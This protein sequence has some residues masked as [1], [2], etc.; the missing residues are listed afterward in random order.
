MLLKSVFSIGA[1]SLLS[2]F[3]GPLCSNSLAQATTDFDLTQ[4]HPKVASAVAAIRETIK[5]GPFDAEWK[6]LER[7]QIPQ[8]YKDAKFGIFIHWGAYSVPAFGSEW[9]P[10]QM[11]IDKNRRGDNFFQHHLNTYGPQKEFGYKDFIPQFKAEKFDAQQWARLF[12]D[13]GAK[14][15]IPV[16][17]HHDGFPM[18][19]CSYTK[20]NSTEMGPKRDVIQ[21]LS[22][23]VRGAGMKFGLSSHR[24]FNWVFYVRSED[25][26][27]ADP[28]YA[29]LYGRPMPFLFAAD[30]SNY[31]KNFPPQDDQFKDDWLARSC[32]LVDRYK[33]DVFWFDFGIAP[34]R[35]LSYQENHFADHLKQ[36]AAY[37]YNQSSEWDG[38]VGII[39]YKWNAFPELAAVYDKERSKEAAIRKP[40]WQT[41]TAVSSS[42]WG[43]T[44]DQ[45]YKTPDRL[46]DDLVD[47]VSKNG[48][49]L[50]NVGPRAD[51]TIPEQDQAILKAIGGWLK[52]NGESIYDTTHWKIFGEGPT[53]VSSGHVAEKNDKRFTAKD[54]RFT[55]KDGTLFVTGLAWPEDGK[56]VVTLLAEGSD[57][58][59]EEIASVEMLGSDAELQWTRDQTG[60]KVELPKEHPS[61]FAYVLTVKSGSKKKLNAKRDTEDGKK[62]EGGGTDVGQNTDLNPKTFPFLLPANKPNKP[63]SAAMQRNYDG[64]MA[65]RPEDNPL[66][67]QFKYTRLKGF[68]YNGGDGTIS[69]RDPSKV[70]FAN[71]KYYVWYTKRETLTPPQG[72]DKSTDTIPSSDWD[73]CD[74][75][76]A[77]STDGFT[78]EEQGIAI[79]R[80]EK[81]QVG[82]RSVSTTDIL[83]WKGKYYLYYQGF[84][85]A[86][87]KRGDDCPVAVSYA[88]SPDGPWVA[89]HK[90]VIPN[91]PKGSWDQYSI[92]DPYPIVRD[93]KI[94]I[95]YKSDFDGD[96]RLIRMQGLVTGDD[97]LG[98]F[99]KHPLNPV[100]A[101]GHE[102]TLFPF[103]EGMAALVTRDGN[104]HNTVQYAADGV[105]FE[106][107]AHVELLPAAA[108]PFVADAFTDTQDGRGITWGIS[109]FTAV[110]GWKTNHAILARFDCDLS[111]DLDDPEMKRHHIYLSPEIHFQ[112]KL[113]GKQR[114]RITTSN[115]TRNATRNVI[116]NGKFDKPDN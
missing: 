40:F 51:G 106:V 87:G 44:E 31:Q 107:A 111:Q 25:F 53:G 57:L 12:K 98:P 66:Y 94:Y 54:L 30:A 18:Y 27:N 83:V 85:E 114:K 49:L 17:E 60:L 62:G 89:H 56:V 24:A 71:G 91:G 20:W 26:D 52:I 13:T 88:D 97:P 116:G 42:S 79:P 6:S 8:W 68:D 82:W 65:P 5:A 32:E 67:S 64:F 19:D 4:P 28:Q 100:I 39:N 3:S 102:T 37:Y 61:E 84:M 103:K 55:A 35:K 99:R 77:T 81:P 74:I 11:Y 29:D 108:G 112:Q 43:Y 59:P 115:Q 46:V 70:I 1:I 73:L 78:W 76:Y 2:L 33:P 63:L 95:Y 23:A 7:Y 45:K 90:V 109:H 15:V 101:S 110:N 58:Y 21:E 105:N 86:S 9:Y 50:L 10:R 92:H 93:G 14:Y 96:P 113:S 69:R 80:P 36:F 75:A 22:E 41:D 38:G 48:C 72:A 34:N 47:I 16:A 104:E